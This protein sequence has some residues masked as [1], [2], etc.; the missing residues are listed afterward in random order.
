MRRESKALVKK[1]SG[2]GE[3]GEAD[4]KA[5]GIERERERESLRWIEISTNLY[6]TK[7]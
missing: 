2:G 7:N 5:I 1:K 3:S 4:C 6:I